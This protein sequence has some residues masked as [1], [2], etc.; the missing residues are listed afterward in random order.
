[1]LRRDTLIIFPF[2]LC[3]LTYSGW[4]WGRGGGGGQKSPPTSFSY[5]TSANER[6]NH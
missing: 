1:M 4:G 5:V 3:C 6:I 2:G